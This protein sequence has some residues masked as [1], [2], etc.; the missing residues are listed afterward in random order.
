VGG[1][2]E[3]RF[4]ALDLDFHERV[5]EAFLDQAEAARDATIVID[6]GRALDIVLPDVVDRVRAWLSPSL[7]TG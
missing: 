4:E 2:D 3:G 7:T 6:A 1:A 5:R